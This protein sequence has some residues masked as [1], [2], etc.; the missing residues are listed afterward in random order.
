MAHRSPDPAAFVDTRRVGDA[1]I[2]VVSEGALK[3]PPRFS[4]P[5]EELRRVLPDLDEQ[6]RVWLG[7]NDIII[8]LGGAVIVVDP[9]MDDPDSRWQRDRA[10]VWPNWP[11]TRSPGLAAAMADLTIEPEDVTHVLITHPHVD[12]YPGVTVERGD[13]LVAER[14]GR[15][16]RVARIPIRTSS[17]SNWSIGWACST[18]SIRN[19]KSC[20]G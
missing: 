13:D 18:S 11:V 14:I 17:V 9:G 12:H 7:L 4:I 2:T 8:R 6:G 10:R 19:G 1:T 16:I 15:E 3:W 5:E 20:R